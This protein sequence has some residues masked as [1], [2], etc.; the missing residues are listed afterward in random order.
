MLLLLLLLLLLILLLLIV[1]GEGSVGVGDAAA[2]NGV[3]DATLSLTVKLLQDLMCHRVSAFD[4]YMAGQLT[5]AGDLKAAMRLGQLFEL[6]NPHAN[7]L[8]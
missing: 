5:V 3:T 1:V 2:G 4:A 8:Q 7:G 6:I